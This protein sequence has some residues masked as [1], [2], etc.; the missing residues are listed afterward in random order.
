LRQR[1]KLIIFAALSAALTVAGLSIA[2]GG[3]SSGTAKS[4]NGSARSADVHRG[5]GPPPGVAFDQDVADVMRQIH[6][7]VE[8]KAPDIADPI[9]QKAQDAGDITSAQA[10]Q[11]RAAAQAIADGKRPDASIRSLLRDADVRKVVRDA[12][13]AAATQAP[14]LGEPLIQKALDDKKI[15]SAQADDIRNKLKNPPPFG[16]G[17]G[18][19]PRGH[20]GFGP[21]GIKVDSDVAAVLDDV[22]Q[23]VEAKESGVEGPILDKAVSDGK[24]TKAQADAIRNHQPVRFDK[25]VA[26]VIGD[27]HQAA[28]KAANADA[29]V[30]KAVDANK[31]TSAQASK[32]RKLLANGPT[33]HGGPP[34]FGDRGGPRGRHWDG[35]R[36][37]PGQR[38]GP[39]P[40]A[41]PGGA[42]PGV[43][44]AV[45]AP[46]I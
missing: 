45:G 46:T 5:F 2:A 33:L 35:P 19:G 18:R 6:D 24:I 42:A 23:A 15:T 16:P 27:V 17:F 3:G 39:T 10:D 34:P 8:Q 11:L 37:G 44:P 22:H 32:I 7:A 30:Q 14:A 36:G 20:H 31:I 4:G 29:I 21:P 28:A 25:D 38:R 43:Q 1:A 40:G 12:F 26:A 13:Q 9:I 41:L